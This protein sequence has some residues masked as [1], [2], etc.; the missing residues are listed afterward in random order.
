[1][2]YRHKTFLILFN[3]KCM[4]CIAIVDFMYMYFD[5]GLHCTFNFYKKRFKIKELDPIRSVWFKKTSN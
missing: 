1:M 3:Y 5:Y 2:R 4:L